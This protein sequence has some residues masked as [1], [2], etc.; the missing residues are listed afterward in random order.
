M[1]NELDGVRELTAQL[2]QLE[3]RLG[4]RTL[5]KALQ[6][7]TTPVR[8]Q[9][10]A[11]APVGNEAHRT[12]RKRLVG[13][14]FAKRSVKRVTGRRFIGRGKVSVALGV[15]AEAFYAIRFYDQGPYTITRRRFS[16]AA[17]HRG[18]SAK[19]KHVIRTDQI[20]PYTLRRRPWFVSTFIANE[21]AMLRDLSRNLKI[22]IDKAARSG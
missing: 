11:K 3:V 1:A 10:R 4:I 14:G 8:R 19:G 12:Y 22:E 6:R 15:R 5:L 7:A 20:K 16:T 17:R 9:L 21:S 13:P 18:G 2:N